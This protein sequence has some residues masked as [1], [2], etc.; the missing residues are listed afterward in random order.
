M[1]LAVRDSGISGS[2]VFAEADIRQGEMIHRM[3][4]K[5]VSLLRCGFG[6]LTGSVRIDDPL[7]IQNYQFIVL[8]DFSIRFN[9]SCSANAGLK[10]E[11][12]LVAVVDIPKGGE[13]TFDYS[14]TMRPSF[15]STFWS[16][17]CRCSS[18]LCRKVIRDIRSVPAGQVRTFLAAGAV[19][20]FMLES[21]RAVVAR[22]SG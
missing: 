11:G 4:G 5:R 12:D 20:D 17:P 10:G 19:Q 3:G 18:P 8:D 9:H 21:A 13:V 22:A 15:Y 1:K 6:I 14:L 7:P 16:M 2:G